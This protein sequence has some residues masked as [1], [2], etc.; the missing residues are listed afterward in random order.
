[1]SSLLNKQYR[2]IYIEQ[3]KLTYFRQLL[4]KSFNN[5][6]AVREIINSD[7]SGFAEPILTQQDLKFIDSLTTL[8]N[9]YL[10]T[11]SIAGFNRAEGAQGKRPLAFIMQKLTDKSLDQLAK[12]RLKINDK[13]IQ[14]L[15]F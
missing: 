5:S 7:Y 11:D 4:I 10:R 12:K 2:H 14:R 8:D 1:M 3:F 9:S 15:V 6:S 13:E